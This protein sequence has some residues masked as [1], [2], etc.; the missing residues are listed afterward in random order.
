[1][2]RFPVCS[3]PCPFCSDAICRAKSPSA[4]YGGMPGPTGLKILAI[5][6]GVPVLFGKGQRG[7]GLRELAGSVCTRSACI[8]YLARRHAIN[9]GRAVFGGAPQNTKRA[10]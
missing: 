8:R 1:M 4:R 9:S 10:N 6:T 2:R 5:S 3:V 7:L